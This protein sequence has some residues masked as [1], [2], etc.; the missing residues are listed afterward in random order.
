MSK[1]FLNH[2]LPKLF[3]TESMQFMKTKNFSNPHPY[4]MQMATSTRHCH[5]LLANCIYN[6]LHNFHVMLS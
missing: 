1:S 2:P 5:V 6:Y 3:T 4:A